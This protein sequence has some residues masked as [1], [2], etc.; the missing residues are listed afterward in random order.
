MSPLNLILKKRD[1]RELMPDEI[2]QIVSG[3]NRGL[4]PD[5]QMTAFLMAV[6]F[7]GLTLGEL[8]AYTEALVASGRVLNWD[9][10][11][12]MVADKHSSGG[13][14]DKTTLVVAPLMAAA[15]VYMPKMSGRGL[16]FTGG[17]IDKLE[18]IP[19]FNTELSLREMQSQVEK[20]GLVVVSQT[21]ELTPADGK[22]YALRDVTATV[23]SIPL[24]AGSIMSKKIAGGASCIVLDVKVGSGAFM[25][26]LADATTLAE[27]M[28][29]LGKAFG[30]RVKALITDMDQPLGRAI[31]NSLEIAEAVSTLQ[32][33][34]PDDLKEL[35][36]N[37]GMHLLCNAENDAD[38]EA[39]RSRLGHL[40]ESGAA[41]EKFMQMVEYQG[42]DPHFLE[43][44]L[45]PAR[46]QREIKARQAG[47]LQK[48]DA[49]C[50]GQAAA[51]LGS[52]R[53]R[54][55]DSPDLSAGIYLHAQ[56][57]DKVEKGMPLMTLHA[58]TEEK[59]AAALEE[60]HRGIE[61]AANPVSPKPLIHDI[62]S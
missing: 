14:G 27:T 48:F 23:D 62:V 4:I 32:G 43:K 45:K 17:T 31:G 16:G 18:S 61:I 1:G 35:A 6:Y 5:Y 15:G 51:L 42:G 21:A 29:S 3:F 25:R 39:A 52:G 30:R 55:A 2:E 12:G 9:H 60:A 26:S 54:K 49:L 34:G 46:F 38:A 13:V 47:Y 50:I 20:I 44:G 41:Y 28:V 53:Q 59:I 58:G 24:I 57:G 56:S 8:T 36:I 37:L 22:I 33:E 11:S 19:G 40:L 10:L 7:R